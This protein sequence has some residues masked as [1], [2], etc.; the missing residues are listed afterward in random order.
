[1]VS[2]WVWFLDTS[3]ATASGAEELKCRAILLLAYFSPQA[4]TVCIRTENQNQAT[5]YPFIRHELFVLA[6]L[7]LGHLLAYFLFCDKCL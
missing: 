5:F 1:M 4:F 2:G 7:T 3:T 6:K